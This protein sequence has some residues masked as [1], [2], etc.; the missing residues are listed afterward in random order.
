MR[1][2]RPLHEL[3]RV[4]PDEGTLAARRRPGIARPRGAPR[5]APR[6][7]APYADVYEQLLD[8]E[9]GPRNGR[10]DFGRGLTLDVTNLDKL[11]F[12]AE[13]FTK[14]DL[15]RYY[16]GVA[17]LLL[18]LLADRPLVLRRFPDGVG[19]KNFYQQKAPVRTPPAVRVEEVETEAGAAR[20]LV[21]GDLPTLLYAVQLGT[22]AMNPWHARL[23]SLDAPDY[24]ILDLDPGPSTP[25]ELVVQTA[26]WVKA[27][28]DESGLRG[29]VK[30]SGKRGVHIAIGLP[31][32]TSSESAQLLARVIA[33]RVVQAH[34]KE[35]TT[36]RS[37]AART[38]RAVY[39]D[40]MQNV[41]GK[42][43]ASAFSVRAT[44]WATV[45]TPVA[46]EE[47][48]SSLDP[49]EFT[50]EMTPSELATRKRFWHEVLRKRN[51]FGVLLGGRR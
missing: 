7:R 8:I 50:I 31:P 3:V 40:Y 39:L 23:P 22:I 51:D 9:R 45:S 42:S 41:T 32:R 15:M 4:L 5:P 18:P 37:R 27:V 26:H 6:P 43:V 48:T 1:L 38:R 29:A 14:G 12:R 24:T 19:G 47:L 10:I 13:R 20:R 21:G 36:V 25:F 28:L 11:Y 34:R 2:T 35:T 46:W 16:V 17:P 33:R 44:E 30:T 49:R